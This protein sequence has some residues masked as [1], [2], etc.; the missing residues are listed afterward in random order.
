[1][2]AVLMG[3]MTDLPVPEMIPKLAG[4]GEADDAL[5][6]EDDELEEIHKQNIHL[7]LIITNTELPDS[8]KLETITKVFQEM[9]SQRSMAIALKH[10]WTG[11]AFEEAPSF[12]KLHGDITWLRDVRRT[13]L[14]LKTFL[15][16]K[17]AQRLPRPIDDIE[18]LVPLSSFRFRNFQ[19]ENL[20]NEQDVKEFEK[21]N[22]EDEK[23]LKTLIHSV[24][25]GASRLFGHITKM[26]ESRQADEKKKEEA[27][28][29][30][31][32]RL[33][34]QQKAKDDAEAKK[35]L[36]KPAAAEQA[37]VSETVQNPCVVL[38]EA[39]EKIDTMKVFG[40]QELF[41]KHKS[42]TAPEEF[43]KMGAYVI[44]QNPD[45]A[46]L[47]EK[48]AVRSGMA[49]FYAQFP[50]QP[51]T[52]KQKRGQQPFAISIKGDIRET[53]L[54]SAPETID[55]PSGGQ[56]QMKALVARACNMVSQYG[57][58]SVCVLNCRTEYQGLPTL[59]WQTKG[60][61]EVAVMSATDVLKICTHFAVKLDGQDAV[62][63]LNKFF[64]SMTA[65]QLD[66]A[67]SQVGVRIQRS[68][69][70][71]GNIY[72]VPF[73]HFVFERCVGTNTSF[74]IRTAHLTKFNVLEHFELAK[75]YKKGMP[76]KTMLA[77]WNAILVATM[78]EDKR[79]EVDAEL[80]RRE[81]VSGEA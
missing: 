80:G 1:M 33:A 70:G 71:P 65:D 74:G 67:L 22:V 55:M 60:Q 48:P 38:T 75:L 24:Q 63:V 20:N 77:F 34:R 4:H 8:E 66:V 14:N 43:E 12:E 69:I 42:E 41:L 2:N 47:S 6:V 26:E 3:E 10:Q 7:S 49:I 25:D 32:E 28:V 39:H 68:I 53:M 61:K 73:G 31:A 50:N 81:V 58:L 62:L 30:E 78:P 37:K 72:Y 16:E 79:E 59:R 21:K 11:N 52:K 13:E 46:V 40:S 35:A 23:L 15:D 27:K 64:D 9:Q 36:K 57:S 5:V 56:D 44:L 17:L 19:V 18:K 54:A 29:K 76:D 51:D 45:L